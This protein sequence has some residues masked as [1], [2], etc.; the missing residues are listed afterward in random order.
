MIL[1]RLLIIC[2]LAI[3]VGVGFVTVVEAAPGETS[4]RR[5]ALVIGNSTY[6]TVPALP[7]TANDASDVAEGLRN[8]G[9]EVIEARN[10]DRRG[11]G[12]AL[13]RFARLADGADAALF[14]YAGHGLQFRGENYLVS[15]DSAPSDE[16]GIPYETTRVADVIEALSNA[17][18]PRILILDACRN[19]PLSDRLARAPRTR[20]TGETRGLARIA[21]NQGMVVAYATQ[22]NDVAADGAGRNSPFTA[23]FVEQLREPGVEVGQLFRRVAVEVNKKTDGR[24]TP[25]LSISLL[26]DFYFNLRE[27]DVTAWSKVRASGDAPALKGFLER[28]PASVLADAAKARLDVLERTQREATLRRQL[29]QFEEDRRKAENAAEA[30]NR[31]ERLRLEAERQERQKLA[32]THADVLRKAQQDAVRAQA[33]QKKLLDARLAQLEEEKRRF[34]SELANRATSE[35]KRAQSDKERERLSAERERIATEQAQRLKAAETA[36]S[37]Q[38]QDEDER[39]AKRLLLLEEQNRKSTLELSDRFKAEQGLRDAAERERVKLLQELEAE[40][41]RANEELL[42][43]QKEVA[44][45]AE[46]AKTA[47]TAS[48]TQ[49]ASLP[50]AVDAEELPTPQDS[51]VLARTINLELSRIGCFNGAATEGWT[52]PNVKEA[53]QLFIKL[54]NVPAP[55]R[56]DPNFLN[57]LQKQDE[58]VCAP[59]CS[60]HQ[61][62]RGN[63]CV[64]KTC[65]RGETLNGDG[66]CVADKKRVVR[67]VPSRPAPAI[68]APAA[69]KSTRSG[70]CFS[71][72]G[73]SFCE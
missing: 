63:A 9:F 14:Y 32:D 8:N 62:L 35:E 24:Q 33:E 42:R 50:R 15:T 16:F 57:L 6:R 55:E 36:A 23:A 45:A 70:R 7:N 3:A 61:L 54:A 30:A 26:G 27:T 11:M 49:M 4:E 34:Q 59:T 29:D 21:Q 71:F 47:A 2:R 52:S 58:R 60:V 56:P 5:V 39:L 13:G 64:A 37:R 53:V 10:L 48:S 67:Q 73:Q 68:R 72:N 44:L 41:R 22:A 65:P 12:E 28:F 1:A 43:V 19:N 31:Q 18:G 69:P 66:G 40:K 17:K 51:R 38:K 20:S 46:A 25:E